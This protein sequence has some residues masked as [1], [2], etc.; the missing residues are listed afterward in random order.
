MAGKDTVLNGPMESAGDPPSL[1]MPVERPDA[2]RVLVVEDHPV[3]GDGLRAL[4]AGVEPFEWVGQ[5]DNSAQ[6]LMMA[7][8][9]Q[10]AIILLDIGL[11]DVNGLDLINQLRRV[12]PAARIVVLTAHSEREYLMTALRLNAH[13][14]LQK[15]MP[16]AAL[17]AAL[18]QVL[19]GERVIGK[20]R[21]LTTVLAQFGQVMQER[22]VQH[23]GMTEQEIEILRLAAAGLNN[24]D[25]GAH[26][27]LSEITVKRK[28]H[29]I[30]R[31]LGVRSRAQAVAE[32][33]RLGLI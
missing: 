30:Y 20:P 21:D 19:N 16:G 18:H 27:F 10:P 17:L 6:A 15:D 32:A 24:R 14:Y 4:L 22:E 28:M 3:F 11:A 2:A 23:S 25:I 8:R 33:I 29:D 13:A 12:C 31:K 26:Q 5:A 1:P 7:R 9:H